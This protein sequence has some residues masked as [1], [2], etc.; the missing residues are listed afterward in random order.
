MA[1]VRTQLEHAERAKVETRMNSVAEKLKKATDLMRG[2][3]YAVPRVASLI[4]EYFE[5]F[6]RLFESNMIEETFRAKVVYKYLTDEAKKLLVTTDWETA[7]DYNKMKA[8]ILLTYKLTPGKY[9][10]T[11][12]K[13]VKKP[14]ETFL[15]ISHRLNV[16]FKY[17]VESREF[18]GRY[19]TSCLS[20]IS[21]KLV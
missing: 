17:Y 21:L 14:E 5:Q 9:R 10:E 16:A 13:L 1:E 20:L 4:P 18:G 7:V 15:H 6:D 2:V 3:L 11:F 19:D 12:Y 8:S